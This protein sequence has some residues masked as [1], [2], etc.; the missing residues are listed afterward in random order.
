[1]A[2]F[3]LLTWCQEVW[4]IL[5]NVAL[6]S[7]SEGTGSRLPFSEDFTAET[8]TVC[9]KVRLMRIREI[10]EESSG[11]KGKNIPESRAEGAA[12]VLVGSHQAQRWYVW[13]RIP[14]NSYT[15]TNP[16]VLLENRSIFK[17]VRQ[18]SQN[19]I[20]WTAAVAF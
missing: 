16:S 17:S 11:R 4:E 12:G 13:G 9:R 8:E 10:N 7:E 20:A 18:T 14:E 15:L 19:P 2:N 5:E 3:R 1:M 6:G